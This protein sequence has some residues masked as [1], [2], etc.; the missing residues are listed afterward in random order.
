VAKTFPQAS[1]ETSKTGSN[2]N[3]GGLYS[4]FF[5]VS[6]SPGLGPEG[7]SVFKDHPR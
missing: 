5:V 2:W 3:E 4:F 7:F 1:A 6:G